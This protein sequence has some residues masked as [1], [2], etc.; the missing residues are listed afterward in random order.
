MDLSK[1]KKIIPEDHISSLE[2]DLRKIPDFSWLLSDPHE[3]EDRLQGD[4]IAQF[5]TVYLGD[6]EKI[7]QHRFSVMMLN[8]TCDL[9]DGRIDTV[10]VVPIIDFQSYLKFEGEN[11]TSESFKGHIQSILRNEITEL[12]YLPRFAEFSGGALALLHQA[13]SVSYTIYVKAI[14]KNQRVA[15]FTQTGF[16][17]FLMKLTNHIARSEA[18]DVIRVQTEA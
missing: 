12:F 2:R 18:R 1:Y 4:L 13:C 7:L 10:T 17:F 6:D 3:S 15:S 14:E 8:N 11:R 16:Y 5:P 9:P